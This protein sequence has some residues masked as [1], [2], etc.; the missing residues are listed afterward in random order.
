MDSSTTPD[1]IDKMHR[2]GPPNGA[3]QDI[4]VRFK[5]HSAKEAFYKARKSLPALLSYVKI[6]PS[7][8]N[9]Q[10]KLLKDAR[11]LLKEYSEGEFFGDNPPEFVFADVHGNIKL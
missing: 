10:Q 4:I 11:E 8:S 1:D 7:L 3:N 5:T 9:D 6:R 2:N